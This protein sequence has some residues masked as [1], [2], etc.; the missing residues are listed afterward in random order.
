M[1]IRATA[2]LPGGR[3]IT[4]SGSNVNPGQVALNTCPQ[5]GHCWSAVS[6]SSSQ[7]PV[8]SHPHDGQVSGAASLIGDGALPGAALTGH[9]PPHRRYTGSPR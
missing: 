3:T 7:R 4:V 8:N 5:A 6:R 2:G 9:P 1:I